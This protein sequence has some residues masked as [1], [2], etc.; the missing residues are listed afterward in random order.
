MPTEPKNL[1]VR[2]NR[3]NVVTDPDQ[4]EQHKQP[5][6]HSH[7]SPSDHEI[8]QTR[9]NQQTVQHQVNRI[10][11]PLRE[12][13]HNRQTPN[14]LRMNRIIST[15]TRDCPDNKTHTSQV[16]PIFRASRR[17]FLISPNMKTS[18][19]TAIIAPN[20]IDQTPMRL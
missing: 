3:V 20:M 13:P 10:N 14:E 5:I 16:F 19:N 7:D 9:H 17:I 11:H 1:R 18:A 4:K 15:I 12:I 6:R 2:H 8:R